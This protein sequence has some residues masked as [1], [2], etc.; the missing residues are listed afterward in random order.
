MKSP[1]GTPI[2]ESVRDS[3][4]QSVESIL[5]GY[6]SQLVTTEAEMLAWESIP[7]FE[8]VDPA[9]RHAFELER[10]RQYAAMRSRTELLRRQIQALEQVLAS[11]SGQSS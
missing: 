1:L 4:R 11:E 2:P 10:Q 5:S 3:V 9:Q 6:Y 7:P 8:D